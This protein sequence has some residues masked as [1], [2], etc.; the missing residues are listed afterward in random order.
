MKDVSF[1][2]ECVE[3]TTDQKLLVLAQ[4][5]RT[6]RGARVTTEAAIDHAHYDGVYPYLVMSRRMRP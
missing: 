1:S 2:H 6:V 5:V 3:Q 4:Y